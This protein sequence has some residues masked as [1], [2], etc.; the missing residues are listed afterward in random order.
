MFAS[1]IEKSNFAVKLAT[2]QDEAEKE[3]HQQQR[4][5]KVKYR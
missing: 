5:H 4:L 1:F 2:L 3:Q